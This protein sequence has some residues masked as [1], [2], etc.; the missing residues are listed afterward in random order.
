MA[1]GS[2]RAP[3][4]RATSPRSPTTR[5]HGSGRAGGRAR[6]G[7]RPC[8]GARAS[9]RAPSRRPHDDAAPVAEDLLL[10]HE[11]VETSPLPLVDA[12]DAE[13]PRLEGAVAG[14]DDQRAREIGA[15]LVGADGEDLL[16][17]VIDT[18]ERLHLFPQPDLGAVLEALLR[19]EVDERLSENL[20]VTR[21]V[22]DV[23][24]GVDGGDLSPELLETLDYTDGAVA[25]SCVVRRRQ[26]ARAGAQDRDVDDAVRAASVPGHG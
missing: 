19:A 25:V 2:A 16:P 8:P 21:D 26:P 5:E 1:S 9:S 18:V 10:A 6:S 11:V 17:V 15:A 12:V 20:R 23:L 22:V 3:P 13:L 7:A 24:L 4:P 14:G